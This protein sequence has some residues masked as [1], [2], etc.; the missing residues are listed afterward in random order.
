M[1]E[2]HFVDLNDTS[3]YT[4]VFTDVK[5]YSEIEPDTA[6]VRAWY[7]KN[8]VYQRLIL[9]IPAFTNGW[10]NTYLQPCVLGTR[11][12]FCTWRVRIVFDSKSET[13]SSFRQ[14]I[15]K[16]QVRFWPDQSL[17]ENRRVY[18]ATGYDELPIL[19]PFEEMPLSLTEENTLF[20]F[21]NEPGVIQVRLSGSKLTDTG[22]ARIVFFAEVADEL[23]F[24]IYN[25]CVRRVDVFDTSKDLPELPPIPDP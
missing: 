13:E 20:R 25:G 3:T 22:N 7:Q 14:R 2:L 9:L 10:I 19:S 4:K 24:F 16:I 5:A 15:G 11:P 1:R 18:L 17:A 21:P 8:K 23:D 6:G 12:I